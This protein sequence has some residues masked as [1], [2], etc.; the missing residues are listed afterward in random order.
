V[1]TIGLAY[2]TV[3]SLGTAAPVTVPLMGMTIS[4]TTA[5]AITVASYATATALTAV[6]TGASAYAAVNGDETANTVALWTGVASIPFGMGA[7][8]LNGAV[9]ARGAYEA[10][11]RSAM[12]GIRNTAVGSVNIQG[13]AAAA[14]SAGGGG[15][16]AVSFAQTNMRLGRFRFTVPKPAAPAAPV[17]PPMPSAAMTSEHSA[18]LE[19][20]RAG[21]KL[22]KTN[23]PAKSLP[24]GSGDELRAAVAARK[25]KKSVAQAVAAAR[26]AGGRSALLAKV[27]EKSVGLIL[28][29]RN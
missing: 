24:T 20:I 2:A 10:G 3:A 15:A 13:G 1:G 28:D 23:G 12:S 17:P 16:Q 14:T 25:E 8:W 5:S 19:S 9:K 18:L 7:G 22:N 6:S 11:L 27:A 4:G 26:Q 29:V 21:T